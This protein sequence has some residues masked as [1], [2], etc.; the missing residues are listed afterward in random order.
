MTTYSPEEFKKILRGEL[1]GGPEAALIFI[2]IQHL[3]G[4]A[5]ESIDHK[6]FV[7][8]GKRLN[9]HRT[10]AMIGLFESAKQLYGHEAKEAV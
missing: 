8:S 3:N 5:S 9:T 2:I 6:Y 1:T 10:N 7:E 4:E